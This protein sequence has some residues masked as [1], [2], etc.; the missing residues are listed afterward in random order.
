LSF[1]A[2]GLRD[3]QGDAGREEL[4]AEG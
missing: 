2:L 3:E 1:D 4:A